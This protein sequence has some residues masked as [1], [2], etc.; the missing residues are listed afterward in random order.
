MRKTL[1]ATLILSAFSSP[2]LASECGEVSIVEMNW[3]SASIV[4]NI[5]KFIMVHGFGCKVDL[6]PG[7]TTPSITSMI[8]KGR[9]DIAPEIW[10]NATQDIIDKAVD[11][12]LLAYAGNSLSDGGKEAFWVPAYMV[13]RDPS[14][15][16]IA[17]IKAHA[18][19]F[20]HPEDPDKHAFIGSPP[21]WNAEITSRNLFNALELDKA[22]FDIV[23]P[24]SSGGLTASI[25][26]ANERE[27]AWF[28]Y[29]WEPT[30]IL[31]KYDMVAVD[32]GSGV[33]VDEFTNCTVIDD[34]ENP[35]VTM[36]PPSPA[37]TV[38]TADFASRAPEVMTYLSQRSFTNVEMNQ[39]LAWMEDNQADGEYAMEYFLTENESKWSTWLTPE[40]TDK[41]REAVSSL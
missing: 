4:A 32:F 37:Q 20:S 18:E 2:L 24:G 1:T 31:G 28:G 25:A 41:I 7:E 12:G 36:Y 40:V 34:C 13:E 35:K 22:G 16:T 5:D 19:L 38:T 11:D 23:T 26:K 29:Y 30:A 39:L 21:G 8:E 9:P 27:E 10:S 14:L 6:V 33:D 15:A 17:G 3:N